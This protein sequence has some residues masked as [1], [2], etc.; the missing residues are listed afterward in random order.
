MFCYVMVFNNYATG[1]IPASLVQIEKEL[2]LSYKEQATLG[3][4]K[5][6]YVL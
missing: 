2:G 6:K 4:I 3:S 1:V 5:N